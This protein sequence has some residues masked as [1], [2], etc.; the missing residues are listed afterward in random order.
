MSYTKLSITAPA[1]VSENEAVIK[2]Q[3]FNKQGL[4]KFSDYS[5]MLLHIL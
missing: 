5:F 2:I 1:S 3:L 4:T